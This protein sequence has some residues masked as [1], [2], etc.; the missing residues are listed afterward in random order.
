MRSDDIIV[1]GYGKFGQ[2]LSKVLQDYALLP[3]IAVNTKE[4]TIELVDAKRYEKSFLEFNLEDDNSLLDI[5]IDDETILIAAMDNNHENLFLVLTLRELFPRNYILAI[6]DSSHLTNKLLKVGVN[7]VIDIYSIS[8]SILLNIL[9]KPVATKFLQG[10][11]NKEHDYVFK[12]IAIKENSPLINKNLSEIDFSKYDIIFIGM[13][14]EEL[15]RQFIF[16]TVG[17]DH[18]I[19]PKDILVFIGKE[20]N[21]ELFE[22]EC[23]GG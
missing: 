15:G 7:K 12:E 23:A 9:K 18:K 11:I 3:K 1:F 17:I 4:E 5:D 8:S 16:S 20:K 13:I 19:D 22:K 2:A 14:D 21:L 6:S 10:F